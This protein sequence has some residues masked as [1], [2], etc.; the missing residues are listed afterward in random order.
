MFKFLILLFAC[1]PAW[2]L[3]EGIW[4]S[5]ASRWLTLEEMRAEVVDGDVLVLGE[6]HAA[7]AS[8]PQHHINQAR[9]LKILPRV[10]LGMEFFEYPRQATVDNFLGGVTTEAEF[11][12]EVGWGGN[13]FPLYRRQLFLADAVVALNMPRAVTRKVGRGELLSNE[14]RALLPPIWERGSE[15]YYERFV[16]AMGGHGPSLENYFMAQSLWDDTMAWRTSLRPGKE[17]FVIIVG[18]FHV[19]YGHGLPARLIRHGVSQ[20]K[21][22]VQ[23]EIDDWSTREEAGA[24][25]PKYGPRAD[26]IWGHSAR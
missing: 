4:S 16:E 6:Q 1:V 9:L 12:T 7:D 18:D 25:N 13:F 20:V 23:V 3:N 17:A 10:S 14:D 24:P 15:L 22:M 2:A 19:L 21:T 26:Y 8:S 11:L 5:R